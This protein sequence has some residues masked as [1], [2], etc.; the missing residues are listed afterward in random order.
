MKTTKIEPFFIVGISVRTTNENGRSMVDIGQLWQ[1]FLSENIAA[2]I[3][4][5][6]D[7]TVYSV[8]TDYESDHTKPYTTILGCRVKS[9]D[10]I[11]KG[12][13]GK[14]IEE[15]NYTVFTASGKVSEGFVGQAWMNIWNAPVARLFTSDFE[16]YD[17]RARDPENATVDIFIATK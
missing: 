15:G 12:L 5:K 8:Y 1:K 9:L 7:E 10:N 3:P 14:H 13:V 17:H 16:V 6:V 11:H 2:Q 4:N